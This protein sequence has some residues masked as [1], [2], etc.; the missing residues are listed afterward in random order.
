MRY[1]HAVGMSFGHREECH[2]KTWINL[3]H[4]VL[5]EKPVTGLMYDCMY[6]ASRRGKNTGT[7]DRLAVSRVEEEVGKEE[8]TVVY[9]GVSLWGDGSTTL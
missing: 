4:I 8:G 1:V 5:R 6:E 7:K 3:E 2:T 9:M